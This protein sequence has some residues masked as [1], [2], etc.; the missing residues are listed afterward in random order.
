MPVPK[1]PKG[2][3]RI[4]DG[5]GVTPLTC[6]RTSLVLILIVGKPDALIRLP[7]WA[8]LTYRV[9]HWGNVGG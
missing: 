4:R 9:N 3:T 1:R 5:S 2:L 8:E 6:V 7:F